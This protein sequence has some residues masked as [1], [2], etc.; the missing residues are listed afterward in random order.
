MQRYIDA[1]NDANMLTCCPDRNE[2]FAKR[3]P[4]VTP[5][6]LNSNATETRHFAKDDTSSLLF[7]RH[8]DCLRPCMTTNRPDKTWLG[9]LSR[10][11]E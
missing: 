11:D 3:A 2:V 4:E 5:N 10:I 1:T 9:D 7:A 6:H 8:M